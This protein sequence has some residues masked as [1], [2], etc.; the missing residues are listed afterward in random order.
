MVTVPEMVY[1][2]DYKR[3]GESAILSTTCNKSLRTES[4]PNLFVTKQPSGEE[5]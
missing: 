1:L 2:K 4:Q 3:H 5:Y